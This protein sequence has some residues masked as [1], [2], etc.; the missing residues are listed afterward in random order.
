MEYILKTNI[1]P[2]IHV[3]T[4]STEVKLVLRRTFCSPMYTGQLWRNYTVASIHKLQVA[5]NNVFHLLLN[6]PKYRSVSIFV[7]YHVS[8]SKAVIRN[9]VYKFILRLDASCKKLVIATI[10]NDLKLQSG[11]PQHW[12][13]LLY[14]H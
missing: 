2:F 9:L 5:Y 7:Q 12:I 4:C 1:K 6:Q 10:N 3:Y 14:I 13:K 11:I 8:N